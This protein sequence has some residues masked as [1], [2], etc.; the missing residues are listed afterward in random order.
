MCIRDRRVA[1]IIVMGHSKCGGVQGCFDMCTG[2]APELN[3]KTSFVG[4]WM[5]LLLPGFERL[6][7][8]ADDASRVSQLE[9]EA[10]RTSLDNLMSF[11]FVKDA[12]EKDRLSLH[13]LH[14][15]IAEGSLR[16]LDPKTDEFVAV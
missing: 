11:P 7:P 8:A 3:E 5:D 1:H 6:D 16:M 14:N 2:N 13:G 10:V 9:L 4:R 15:D 12:V